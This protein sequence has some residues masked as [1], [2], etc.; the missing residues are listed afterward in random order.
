MKTISRVREIKPYSMKDLC[1]I[2]QVGD[3]TMRKWLQP[4]EAE[5]GKRQ[6]RIYNVTQVTIIFK[7]LGIPCLLE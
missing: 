6:G 2:Y 7:Y 5:I 3:K 1:H 4:F